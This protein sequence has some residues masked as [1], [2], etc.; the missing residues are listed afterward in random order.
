MDLYKTSDIILAASLKVKGYP[1]E[2]IEKLGNKGI[3][4]FSDVDEAIVTE[5]DLG[6]ILVEPTEFNNA[7]KQL[8]TSA[9][10]ILDSQGART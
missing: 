5:Y 10:R 9:R 2:G 4:I 6:K 7:I 8:T 1:L 3:F